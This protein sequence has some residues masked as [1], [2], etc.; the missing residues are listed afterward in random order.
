[1]W[2][3]WPSGPS[4]FLPVDRYTRSWV[5]YPHCSTLLWPC[6]TV[7]LTFQRSCRTVCTNSNNDTERH[8]SRSSVISSLRY[9]LYPVRTLKYPSRNLVPHIGRVSRT[10][11][12]VPRGTKGQLSYV[13][14]DRLEIAFVSAQFHRLKP[15]NDGGEEIGILGENLRRRASEIVTY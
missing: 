9:R 3:C 15:L 1:M 7:I 14:L 11:M 5:P 8:S 13:K 12:R 4:D 10:T 6:S 2:T